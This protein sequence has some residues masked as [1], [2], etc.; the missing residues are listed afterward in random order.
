VRDPALL[1][2]LEGAVGRLLQEVERLRG[3]V[4]SGDSRVEEVEG[5]LRRLSKGEADPTEI[6]RRARSLEEENRILRDRMEV[7]RRTVER[8]LARVRFLEDRG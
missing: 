7:A 2:G 8:L 4:E 5:L 1:A 6:E 3:Q